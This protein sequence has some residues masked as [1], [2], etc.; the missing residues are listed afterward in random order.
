MSSYLYFTIYG[1][2]L[3]IESADFDLTSLS[4]SAD[5]IYFTEKPNQNF[6]IN[7]KI[8]LINNSNTTPS[9][10]F[11]FSTAMCKVFQKNL[12]SREF[13]YKPQPNTTALLTDS[14]IN[15]IR[16]AE[17]VTT[18]IK[19]AS[20]VLYFYINSIVGEYLD[21]SGLMRVHAC[22]FLH[23]ET[24]SLIYGRSGLGKSTL[25]HELL[26]N[27]F[28]QLYSD[29]IS[30]INLKNGELLP[31]PIRISIM[32]NSID[33]LDVKFN[34]FFKTKS[35]LP[36]LN[37][38]VAPAKK[39]T[40]VFYLSPTQFKFLILQKCLFYFDILLGVG[41]IQMH[42]FLLRPKNVLNLLK[43]LIN[44]LRLIYLLSQYKLNTLIKN[45]PL[46]EKII[47]LLKN[48]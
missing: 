3:V 44:R 32:Q 7:A 48:E 37:N 25:A 27:E 43:I 18:D 45:Q 23:N 20:D 47:I 29:E 33:G 42:E 2:N 17:L 41:L 12:N 26:N 40:R 16:V 31:Y 24:T 15:K 6:S 8:T 38:K 4:T 30:L 1:L 21:L 9:G 19:L 10:F 22:S 14:H 5:F 34:Y 28:V 46:P 13:L 35:L 36:L 39:L 11:I